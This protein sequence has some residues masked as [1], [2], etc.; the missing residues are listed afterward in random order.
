MFVRV[1]H[2][3]GHS[4]LRPED[5]IDAVRV[6]SDVGVELHGQQ[7]RFKGISGVEAG[8]QLF[9]VGRLVADGVGSRPLAMLAMY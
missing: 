9:S 7:T 4:S 1:E 8:F 5:R 6:L 3:R 2:Q